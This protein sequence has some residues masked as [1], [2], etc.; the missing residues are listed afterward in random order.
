MKI[1]LGHV[2]KLTPEL[3]AYT[4]QLGV[5]S[6][7]FSTP[8]IPV[9]N[10]SWALKDLVNLKK[11]CDDNGL[12][13]ETIENVPIEFYDKVLL[14]L[15]GRD[16]QIEKYQQL[17]VNMSK[18]EIPI[19][20]Y[21]FV[22]TFVWRTGKEKG[23]GGAMVTAFDST[24]TN[25]Q[26]TIKAFS[27]TDVNIPDVETMWSNYTYFMKAVLPTAKE[28][29]VKL[30]LH[31]DDPPV[32]MVANVAR[33]FISLEAF[34]RAEAIAKDNDMWGLDLC[35]GCCSEMGGAQ[36]VHDFIDYFGP[37]KRII[38]VHFRDVQGSVPHFKECFLGEGNFNPSQ[39]IKQLHD[40]GFDNYIMDDHV[41]E[42]DCD[43]NNTDLIIGNTSHAYAIGYM[44]GILQTLGY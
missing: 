23:R 12:K 2:K 1:C 35:L 20:G 41:P 36:A 33:L 38:Y 29:G 37:K 22:P 26:N 3:V 43:K 30:A 24:K 19:L 13:C 16:E 17:L 34:K 9:V 32:P 5:K 18:A 42:M 8:H 27:R 7:Q 15:P 25:G 21:H 4:K 39:V 31:P 10:G 44:Q 11:Q 14:G 40:V 6:I 28:V